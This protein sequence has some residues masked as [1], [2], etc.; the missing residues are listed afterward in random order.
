MSTWK[1]LPRLQR[2][3][4]G[5]KEGRKE[6]RKKTSLK[7]KKRGVPFTFLCLATTAELR[8]CLQTLPDTSKHFQ[9]LPDTSTHLLSQ[10]TNNTQTPDRCKKNYDDGITKF[11]HHSPAGVGAGDGDRAATLVFNSH[12]GRWADGERGEGGGDW[13]MT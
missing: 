9:T 8:E 2:L 1:F 3:W 11:R 12:P 13:E 7:R 10:R 6:G 4:G 5:R